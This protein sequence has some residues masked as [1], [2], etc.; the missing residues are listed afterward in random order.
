MIL[1]S[2]FEEEK[3]TSENA[4]DAAISGIPAAVV[5]NIAPAVYGHAH[6]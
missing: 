4:G 3:E 6:L 5:M 1:G 2:T